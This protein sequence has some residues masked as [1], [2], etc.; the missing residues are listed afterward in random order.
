MN[1]TEN[2]AQISS[3]IR[4]GILTLLIG[5]SFPYKGSKKRIV[6]LLKW[7]QNGITYTKEFDLSEVATNGQMTISV[8]FDGWAS[9]DWDGNS[10][11]TAEING[12][13]DSIIIGF[14]NSN[15]YVDLSTAS[16]SRLTLK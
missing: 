9:I 2:L 4:A 6:K 11:P 15:Y 1:S 3:Q 13:F 12:H 8:E 16:I 5:N 7:W 14:K 10:K